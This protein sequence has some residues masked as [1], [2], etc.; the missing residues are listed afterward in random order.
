MRFE[1]DLDECGDTPHWDWIEENITKKQWAWLWTAGVDRGMFSL[2]EVLPGAYESLERLTR[3]HRVYLI[4][5]RPQAARRDTI[6]W[7]ATK[8]PFNFQGIVTSKEKWEVECDVYL[9]DKPENV[10]DLRVNRFTSNHVLF[11]RSYN[12]YFKWSPTVDNWIEFERYV[13]ILERRLE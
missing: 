11:R 3:D 7:V 1:L 4:T 8:L 9:D 5:N 6:Y 10:H 13:R 12:E 2:L